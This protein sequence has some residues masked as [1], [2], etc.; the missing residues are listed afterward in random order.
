MAARALGR[1][2]LTFEWDA[3]RAVITRFD[4]AQQAELAA[5][6]QAYLGGALSPHRQ[7]FTALIGQ[8]LPEAAIVAPRG[9]VSEHGASR[10]FRRT[11]EGVY[12]M[13]DL[14]ARTQRMAAFLRAHR[15]ANPGRAVLALG[16]SN[17]CFDTLFSFSSC[18]WC[19]SWSW[20]S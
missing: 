13:P 3:V 18:K 7:D 12:D 5:L 14:A 8:I 6:M 10:F 17:G 20:L 4:A 1:P 15:E 19:S 2:E 11:A 9:D 16:Y